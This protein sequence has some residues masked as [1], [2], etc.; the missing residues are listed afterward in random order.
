VPVGFEGH[1]RDAVR[2][3]FAGAT[4][5]S[6]ETFAAEGVHVTPRP[7]PAPWPFTAMIVGFGL[8]IVVCAE[9]RYV[10]WAREHAA[11][12]VQRVNYL[13][14]PLAAEGA[15]RGESLHPMPPM[16][17][18]ALA[19]PP[20][21]SALTP[22]YSLS[23]VEKPWMDQRQPDDRFTNALGL[24]VQVHRTYRN[25]FAYV[26][27]D[28]AGDPVAVAGVFDTAG[29]SE[30]GVDVDEGHRG[31]GLSKAVV[32][33]AAADLI[34]AGQTPFYVCEVRN[35]RSQH[36]ALATGFM[37]VCSLSLVMPAGL[38]LA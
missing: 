25:Q 2:Q 19:R 27:S 35:I 34:D 17:G 29:L 36:T 6:P 31:L 22:G 15:C 3:I 23:R 11:A 18:W 28:S 7:D 9:E 30:I 32:S 38:G 21:A 37:P 10:E 13:A 16:L 24:S 4:A 5:C 26:V 14:I 20:S 12:D 8:G 33:A 1:Q